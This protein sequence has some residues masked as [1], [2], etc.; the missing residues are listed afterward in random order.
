MPQLC[1]GN[2][3]ITPTNGEASLARETGAKLASVLESD[4]KQGV[5]ITVTSGS[6][7]Q[8]LALP[9]SAVRLLAGA[10]AELGQGHSVALTSLQAELTSQQAADLLNVSRPH[11]VKLLDE[12][13]IPCRKVG[14][15]RR[16]PLADLLAYKA[17][18]LAR[19]HA[20]LD[21]LQALSQDLGMG[22]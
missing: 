16:V 18:H 3:V 7:T 6:T 21:E 8:E 17:D 12:G 10:L 14:T 22:Y 13:A 2:Q 9:P 1:N 15:H 5:R 11:L 4:Q 20:A 19:R